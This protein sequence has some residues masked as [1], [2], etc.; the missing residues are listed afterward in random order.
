MQQCADY[1]NMHSKS[2]S[3]ISQEQPGFDN[4]QTDPGSQ[5]DLIANN[6]DDSLLL[7]MDLGERGPEMT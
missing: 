7:I 5:A 3:A 1:R 6:N 2:S 4:V